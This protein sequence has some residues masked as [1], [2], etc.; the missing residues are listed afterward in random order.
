MALGVD[1]GSFSKPEP[2]QKMIRFKIPKRPVKSALFQYSWPVGSLK[3][4]LCNM[5]NSIFEPRLPI[6]QY[7]KLTEYAFGPL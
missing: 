2:I 6:L 4:Q 3:S 1:E 7:N 5:A